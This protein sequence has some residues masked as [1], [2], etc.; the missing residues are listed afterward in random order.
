MET[1][2][3]DLDKKL[4]GALPLA[5]IPIDY[6]TSLMNLN[7]VLH[8]IDIDYGFISAISSVRSSEY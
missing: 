7:Q 5:G 2:L 3:G 1:N 4:A 6:S 8:S